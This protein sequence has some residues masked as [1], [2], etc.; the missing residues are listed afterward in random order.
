MIVHLC[1]EVQVTSH[2]FSRAVNRHPSYPWK[3]WDGAEPQPFKGLAVYLCLSSVICWFFGGKW[4]T[5]GE[6]VS[7]GVSSDRCILIF[8]MQLK[9]F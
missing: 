6:G 3:E 2:S 1:R 9:P 5:Q 8:L 4:G 7:E